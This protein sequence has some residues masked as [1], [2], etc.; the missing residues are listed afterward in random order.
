MGILVK[1]PRKSCDFLG[2]DVR[3]RHNDAGADAKICENQ[4][5]FYLYIRKNH[6]WPGLH[7]GSAPYPIVTAVC[8][9]LTS[10]VYDSILEKC[11]WGPGEVLEIFITKRV[12]TLVIAGRGPAYIEPQ[13]WDYIAVQCSCLGRGGELVVVCDV[14][15]TCGEGGLSR[16]EQLVWYF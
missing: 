8:L 5:R 1:A 10:L 15:M 7:P 2:Y 4:L 13:H 14:C 6:W 16:N 12:A 11:F 9:Y 3:A